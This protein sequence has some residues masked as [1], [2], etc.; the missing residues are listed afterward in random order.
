MTP[1][2]ILAVARMYRERLEREHIPKHAMDPNRRFSPNMTGFHHQML[3]HAHYM[4]DA[5]EQYAPDPSRE[6]KTMQR[7]AACQTLLWL[8]GW[9]TKNEIKS[10]LQEADEL[11]AI[12]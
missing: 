11:A 2:K 7:L 4:L 1:E 12:D 10:H 8:A 6:Q 9:Y 3:G 5:V